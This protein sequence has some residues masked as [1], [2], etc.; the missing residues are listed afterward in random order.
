M[1][2]RVARFL[3]KIEENIMLPTAYPCPICKVELVTPKELQEHRMR[4]PQKRT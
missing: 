3:L 1:L 4:N 2:I